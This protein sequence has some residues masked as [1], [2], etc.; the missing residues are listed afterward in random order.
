MKVSRMVST[1]PYY[2]ANPSSG[3]PVVPAVIDGVRTSAVLD[4]GSS[5]SLALLPRLANA[6]P[7]FT[8]RHNPTTA[9]AAG[10][11]G[12]GLAGRQL[13]RANVRRV[14]ALGAH[15]LCEG[16]AWIIGGESGGEDYGAVIAAR[17]LQHG[18][19][20]FDYAARR[21]WVEWKPLPEAVRPRAAR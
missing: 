10:A 13:T 17:F 8:N 2:A 7:E 16:T 12:P 3:Q 11:G 4:T 18:R 1:G 19:L 6:H 20:T 21:I 14:D 9:R 5:G 15:F